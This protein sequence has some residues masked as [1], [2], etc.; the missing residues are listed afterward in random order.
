MVQT[1]AAICNNVNWIQKCVSGG[2]RVFTEGLERKLDFKF[3]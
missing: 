3:Y 1:S 2:E